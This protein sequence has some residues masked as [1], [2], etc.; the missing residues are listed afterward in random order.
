MLRVGLTGGLACGKSHVARLLSAFGCYV[1]MADDLG[2]AVLA[3]GGE[4]YDAVVAEFGSPVLSDDGR[5]IDRRKLASAVFG[6]P[7]QLAKLNSV[8]HPA[9]FAREEAFT[10]SAAAADTH[11]IVVVEAAI[12]IETGSY[13]KYDKL[14]VVVCSEDQQM[15]RAMRRAGQSATPED[16]R[17][18][19]ERQI[20]VNEKR[21]FADFVIDTSGTREQTAEQT[22]RVYEELRRIAG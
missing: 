22:R 21:K 19:I 10:Q 1:I 3:P 5:S 7:E 4:A 13:K 20:P 15:E 17:A 12:L 2:H 8:V 6:N 18:R 16:V 9:V 14:I 11:A